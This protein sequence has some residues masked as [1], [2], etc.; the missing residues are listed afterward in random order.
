VLRRE[1]VQQVRYGG[2]RLLVARLRQGAEVAAVVRFVVSGDPGWPRYDLGSRQAV[3]FAEQS[4]VADDLL[5]LEREARPG[6]LV[7][8]TR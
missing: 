5:R 6:Q 2:E 3:I 1:R 4:A 8:R 7:G